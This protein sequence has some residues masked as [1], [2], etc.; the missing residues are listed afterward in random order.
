MQYCQRCGSRLIGDKCRKCGKSYEKVNN[1]DIV[2][3]TVNKEMRRH[4]IRLP[5]TPRLV[6]I[7]AI[8]AIAV[9]LSYILFSK[10]NTTETSTV[11]SRVQTQIT[12]ATNTP[13]AQAQTPTQT[14]QTAQTRASLRA[15]HQMVNQIGGTNGCF[16]RVDGGV[17]NTGSVDAYNV[18]VTC[19]AEEVSSQTDMGTVKAGSTDAFQVLLNYDCQYQRIEECTVICSNC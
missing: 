19:T 6:I 13:S 15:F 9:L 2:K 11:L 3:H 14:T 4:G 10:E 7:I 17:S 16:G 1:L 12:Q 18:V 5:T 8:V